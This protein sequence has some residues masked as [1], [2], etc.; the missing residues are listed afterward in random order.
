MAST[1]AVRELDESAASLQRDVFDAIAELHFRI[2]VVHSLASRAQL[3]CRRLAV[4]V[5]R[6]EFR[7]HVLEQIADNTDVVDPLFTE[8]FLHSL[9]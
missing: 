7:L 8:E 2:D 1:A 5:E 9:D 4:S 6:L 3:I